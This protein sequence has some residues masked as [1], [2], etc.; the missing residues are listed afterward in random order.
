[1]APE[2]AEQVAV[3]HLL[4]KFQE[5][6]N[7][8]EVVPH[9]IQ[10]LYL[11]GDD[12]PVDEELQQENEHA[13]VLQVYVVAVNEVYVVAGSVDIGVADLNINQTGC[14][15]VPEYMKTYPVHSEND[16]NRR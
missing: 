2:A 16:L 13:A 5:F 1:V 4:V 10:E 6:P 15:A 7:L 3:R 14:L 8:I 11:V 9:L 12:E